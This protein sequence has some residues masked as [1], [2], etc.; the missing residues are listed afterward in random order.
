[1]TTSA[2]A[3]CTGCA[4]AQRRFRGTVPRLWCQRFHQP[5][6][7]RCLDYRTK[8]AAIAIALDYLK[9]TSIK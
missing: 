6:M 9:R 4:Q 3:E 2:P 1:M 8:R 7:A 5:A